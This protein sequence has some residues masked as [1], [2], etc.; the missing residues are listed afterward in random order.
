MGASIF[1]TAIKNTV[2]C[3]RRDLPTTALLK[4]AHLIWFLSAYK[5]FP[6]V[7]IRERA[8]NNYSSPWNQ[9]VRGGR[10]VREGRAGRLGGVG[11]VGRFGKSGNLMFCLLAAD[12]SGKGYNCGVA[13]DDFG[14][15]C[16]LFCGAA[17]WF[18]ETPSLIRG[19]VCLWCDIERPVGF[20]STSFF[21][22]W[23]SAMGGFCSL[24]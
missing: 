14:W 22:R 15:G 4:G 13:G 24:A 17:N 11:E 3:V 20:I 12:P 16:D 23:F 5:I 1:R 7:S 2:D 18:M 10:F 19:L 8:T 21:S 6:T 9:F